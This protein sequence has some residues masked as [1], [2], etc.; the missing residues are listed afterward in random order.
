MGFAA[1]DDVEDA[2]GR[3]GTHAVV[4]RSRRIVVEGGVIRASRD[5]FLITHSVFVRIVQAVAVAIHVVVSVYIFW[6]LTIIVRRHA[7]VPDVEAEVHVAIDTISILEDLDVE[8]ALDV[9]TGCEL[10]DQDL[11]VRVAGRNAVVVSIECKPASADGIINDNVST[12]CSEA[13][14]KVDGPWIV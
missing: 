10:G 5:L 1:S 11:L 2:G 14:L 9:T 3:V 12:R 13:R 7:G 6:V 8:I 4:I